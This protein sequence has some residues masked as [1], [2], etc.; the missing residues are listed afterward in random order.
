MAESDHRKALELKR[1]IYGPDALTVGASLRNLARL[2]S[3]R[4]PA[5]GEKLFQEA[6]DLYA[7]NPK[8]PPFDYTSA[9][10]GLAESQRNRGDLAA[11]RETLQHASDVAEKGLGTKHPL[12]AAVLRDRALVDQSAHEYGEAEALLRQAI[13]IVEET[14]GDNHPDLAKYL[15]RLAAVYDLAGDYR[16]AEPLYRRSLE[17]SDRTLA[18]MLTVGSEANKAAVLANLEDPIPLLLDFQRRAGDRC[19]PPRARSPSKPSRAAKAF[20]SIRCMTGVKA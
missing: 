4:N 11:A 9:L 5:E 20:W 7:K 18:E 12:Y 6:V 14:Q 19:S 3:S 16:A 13:A 2:V 1:K 10:L 8:A 15:Q 17:I